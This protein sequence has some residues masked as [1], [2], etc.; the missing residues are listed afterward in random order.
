M[1]TGVG[2]MELSRKGDACLAERRDTEKLRLW[3]ERGQGAG[4]G[5]PLGL[6]AR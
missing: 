6:E 3:P 5:E 2:G 1:S 4:F